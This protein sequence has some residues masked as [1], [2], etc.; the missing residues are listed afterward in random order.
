VDEKS[1]AE[2]RRDEDREN[3]ELEQQLARIRQKVVVLSGKGGVGKSTVAANLALLMAKSGAKVG[4][5]DVDFHGPSIPRLLGLESQ[6]V[7]TD[8]E[9]LKP[10]TIGENLKVMSLGF[11]LRGQDDTVI[12]RG[13]MK[14]GAIRQLIKD[15]RWGDLDVL[16]F[17]CPPGT[18]DE[19]LSVV[20]LIRNPTGA[21]VVTTPQALS[22]SDVRRSIRFCQKVNLP[23]LGLIENM[24][25]YVCPN[26]GHKV[27]IFKA[28]GG[29]QM[30]GELDVPFLGRIPLDPEIVR[31]SDEGRPFITEK[32]GS[33]AL[34]S[35]N[36][37]LERLGQEFDPNQTVSNQ[38][39][40]S[41]MR[42]YA[43]PL[44][45]GVLAQ[46]FGHSQK[47]A[48]VEADA[49]SGSICS[50]ENR[51]PPP[52][53]PGA[54]PKWLSELGVHYI[55]CG[56]MGRRAQDLFQQSGIGVIIGAPA[57]SAEDLVQAHLQGT[58]KSGD[59]ICD[60]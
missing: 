28:G 51:T 39:A 20:Q 13:P 57:Q 30:A 46:H 21:V 35:L 2:P 27:D 40:K 9:T 54:L 11:L 17:D 5:L 29:E 38:A 34:K 41:E 4:L 14:M 48:I 33:E 3:A 1:N 60:H 49:E 8:G 53:E 59:N 52:H 15:V 22:V 18:G 50:T 37:I 55:I 47:F 16:I 58:L 7:F 36:S 32:T 10:L 42:R 31:A 25:G 24:S 45:E 6:E 56:G 26:C 23:V 44:V 19:P 12:W 43:I